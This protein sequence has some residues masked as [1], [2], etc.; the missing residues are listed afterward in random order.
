MLQAARETEPRQGLP[1]EAFGNGL[2]AI[3]HLRHVHRKHLHVIPGGPGGRGLLA[4]LDV[5]GLRL[6]QRPQRVVPRGPHVLR[7][8]GQRD[9]Q[10]RGLD[11][12]RVRRQA[13]RGR[14]QELREQ[15]SHR[16][17]SLRG[18][19]RLPGG[20]ELADEDGE[21]VAVDLLHQ[22]AGGLHGGDAEVAVLLQ[23]LGADHGAHE[24]GDH[25]GEG[26]D[27]VVAVAGGQ[28]P[29][30]A[31]LHEIHGLLAQLGEQLVHHH[32]RLQQHQLGQPVHRPLPGRGDLRVGH[33]RGVQH[34]VHQRGDHR[35]QSVIP[36]LVVGDHRAGRA[37]DGLFGVADRLLHGGDDGGHV[38]PD[39]VLGGRVE[40]RLQSDADPLPDQG[41]VRLDALLEVGHKI[42]HGP[43]P[44]LLHQLPDAPGGDMDLLV[45]SGGQVGDDPADEDRHDLLQG[46]WS[47]LHDGLPDL[48]RRLGHSPLLIGPHHVQRG[49]RELALLPRHHPLR[50]QQV[51]A[52]LPRPLHQRL[53]HPADQ[54]NRG[55]PGVVGLVEEGLLQDRHH[56]H[57]CLHPEPRA[58]HPSSASGDVSHGLGLIRRG[59]HEA[60]EHL[61]HI[62]KE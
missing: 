19:V 61:L 24:G 46:A 49:Q 27:D 36:G 20:G 31:D 50:H 22:P 8:G 41:L 45:R 2:D 60:L 23:A 38:V 25:H 39:Q 42:L 11:H 37:A 52:E 58:D 34:L 26:P 43:R 44:Q 14:P 29:E 15:A 21:A 47:V 32:P 30:S 5:R 9:L 56:E 53:H 28:A 7:R 12:A 48:G 13:R 40:H 59:R 55:V 57:G 10:Q 35:V 62:G 54:V 1:V 6:G 17:L 16:A 51:L 18:G 3:P 33:R 4:D